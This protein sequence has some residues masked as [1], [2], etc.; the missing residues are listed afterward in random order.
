MLAIRMSNNIS[1]LEPPSKSACHVDVQCHYADVNVPSDIVFR[2][3]VDKTIQFLIDKNLLDNAAIDL[4]ILVVDKSESQLLNNDYSQQNKPTNVLSF[5][6]DTPDIFKPSQESNILGDIVI[7]A[8]II[9]L[10]AQQQNKLIEHHW[11]HML[12]HGLLHLLGYD[13]LNNNDA[14]IMENLEIEI[15][16]QLGY[17]NPYLELNHE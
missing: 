3:W 12:V 7:C 10:E 11:A 17:K 15:L 2:E 5:P 6:F 8:P 4:S 9:E 13:H 14:S 1:S 16:S